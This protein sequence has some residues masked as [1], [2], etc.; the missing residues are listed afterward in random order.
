[1]AAAA[2]TVPGQRLARP[3][4]RQTAQLDKGAR[5]IAAGA[6]ASRVHLQCASPRR[7]VVFYG[8]KLRDSAGGG[9]GQSKARLHA[10]IWQPRQQ[11]RL[12]A[13]A[14]TR[15]K[16]LIVERSHDVSEERG[17]SGESVLLIGVVDSV[18]CS[19]IRKDRGLA[20]ARKRQH[21]LFRL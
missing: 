19:L 7:A 20:A 2:R 10:R 18:H 9:T 11:Q 3:I 5:E 1:M 13:Q 15:E 12:T 16:L 8:E 17:L 6:C 21:Q 14:G 4:R